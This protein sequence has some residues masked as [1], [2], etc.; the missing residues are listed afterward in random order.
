MSDNE[1]AVIPV[2]PAITGP[3][4]NLRVDSGLNPSGI[5]AGMTV[6]LSFPRTKRVGN[7]RVN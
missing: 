5:I 7:L 6:C 4:E 1:T 3:V 2:S